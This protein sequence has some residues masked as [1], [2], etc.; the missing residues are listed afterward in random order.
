DAY[1]LQSVLPADL[2]HDALVAA[3]GRDKKATSGLVFIL[4]GSAGLESVANVEPAHVLAAL[5]SAAGVR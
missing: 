2:D 4:D 5:A 1:G 3:M